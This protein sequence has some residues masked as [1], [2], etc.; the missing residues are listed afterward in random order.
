MRTPTVINLADAPGRFSELWSPKRIAQVDGYEVKLAKAEGAFVWHAHADEDEL[1]LVTQG[2]LRIE[3]ENADPVVLGPGELT[4]IPKGV[5]HRPV[6]ETGPVHMVLLERA[7]VMNT[8]DAVVS[9]KTASIEDL[10]D[11]A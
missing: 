1:F 9:E 11:P 4:V 2:V 10:S 3:I 8:G 7:G 6:V 5:R